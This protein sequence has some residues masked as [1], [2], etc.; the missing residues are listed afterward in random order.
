MVA[1]IGAMLGAIINANIFGELSVIIGSIGVREKE[2]Q[3][4]LAAINDVM[5]NLD[6]P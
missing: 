4:E 5:I 3:N 2:F 1:S 6:I